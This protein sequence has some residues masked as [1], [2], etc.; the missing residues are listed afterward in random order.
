LR[1]I[2]QPKWLFNF[3]FIMLALSSISLIEPSPYDL[4]F[5]ILFGLSVYLFYLS[6]SPSALIPFICL[7]LF[8]ESH[9]ASF[10]MIKDISRFAE[11]TVISFYLIMTWFC[12]AGI[13]SR[14][15]VTAA[16][17]IFKGYVF[18]AVLAAFFGIAAYYHLLPFSEMFLMEG[19][20]KGFFKDPNVF[21][22]FLIP[23]S[24]FLLLK[25]E[26]Y[27]G[28]RML[29]VIM[30]I[31]FALLAIGVLLSFSRAAWGHFMLSMFIY[32]FFYHSSFKRRL[33]LLVTLLAFS[34]PALFYIT[35]SSQTA[36]LLHERFGYQE[37]DD[38][39]FTKQME[40]LEIGIK[41]PLG[42]GPG[43]SEEVFNHST[44]SLYV[45]VF[46]ENGILGFIAFLV[47]YCL[48]LFQSLKNIFRH[49]GE[50]KGLFVVV[51]ASLLGIG[52][53]SFF[54]DTLHWRHFWLL[55]AL[56][57]WQAEQDLNMDSKGYKT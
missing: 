11:F 57:W 23:P 46:T 12:F 41:H 8:I 55:L 16:E 26:K 13:V 28:R 35:A 3:L 51:F 31:C 49:K 15:K 52:F 29:M 24:I 7:F 33:I 30:A 50:E 32:L 47:F 48:V 43:Q 5:P 9:L 34:I 38:T 17:A 40:A 44:H 42:I 27:Q 1:S 25:I 2:R 53:N 54:I 21:G 20:V 19:R 18:S 45:R 36:G 10:F 56:P 39:R 37:Y 14:F 4:L 22:P 6:F